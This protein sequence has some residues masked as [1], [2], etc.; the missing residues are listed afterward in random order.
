MEDKI[1]DIFFILAIAAIIIL[2]ING[3]IT[4]SWFWIFS[5]I[6]FLLGLG[7]ILAIGIILACI[8]TVYLERRKEK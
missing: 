5:P 2:K 6:I 7:I 4:W 8:I 1:A 3:T